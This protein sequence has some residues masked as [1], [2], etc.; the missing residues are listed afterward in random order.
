MICVS[1]VL[2]TTDSSLSLD[3]YVLLTSL[4]ISNKQTHL[5]FLYQ[6]CF[7]SNIRV[8]QVIEAFFCQKPSPVIELGFYV[9]APEHV[10]HNVYLISIHWI[11]FQ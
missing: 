8:F 11:S 7:V 9:S 3:Y 5:V 2:I 10:M 4:L 1:L 6:L